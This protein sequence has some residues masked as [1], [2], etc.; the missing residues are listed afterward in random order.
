[1]K[2]G[3]TIFI[4]AAV[5]ATIGAVIWA[6]VNESAGLKYQ[7]GTLP[8]GYGQS[9]TVL[10]TGE[11]VNYSPQIKAAQTTAIARPFKHVCGDR[12]VVCS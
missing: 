6:K 2:N 9:T 7:G 12:D 10:Q 11:V 3:G 5:L 8:Y 4:G 1:M